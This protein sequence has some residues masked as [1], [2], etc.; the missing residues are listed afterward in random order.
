MV[1]FSKL[2]HPVSI[3]FQFGGSKSIGSE[4]VLNHLFGAKTNELFAAR[5]AAHQEKVEFAIMKTLARLMIDK[6]SSGLQ[7]FELSTQI[8]S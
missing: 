5:L 8:E 3:K 2:L 7:S 1:Y 4:A 6:I